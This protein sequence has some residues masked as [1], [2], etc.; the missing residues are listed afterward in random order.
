[1]FEIGASLQE[2][3]ARRGLSPEDVQKAIRIR[4][5]Y[6]TALEEE[7]WEL[8]PGDAYTKGFL[9]SYAEF[10]GLDGNLYVDEYNSRISD[11]ENPAFVPEP[12]PSGTARLGLLRPLVAIAAIVG[13]VAAV[14]AWQLGRAP[15][16][17]P[18]TSPAKKTHTTAKGGTTTHASTTKHRTT[19]K[20]HTTK[21]VVTA[22]HAVLAATNGRVW[23]Q[24]RDGDEAGAVIFEGVLEQGKTLPVTLSP[25]VWVRIGAPWNLE[26]RLGGRVLQG[27]PDQ[28]GNVLVTRSGL[29]P[30]A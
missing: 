21:P 7:R 6:L 20:Q 30:A 4:G 14:A 24:V 3:R 8:L 25:R 10:L 16:S 5:R 13:I 23:L 17:G 18:Q 19:T 12:L 1:M 26:I 27:L 2:A 11:H 29:A 9:R 28:P 15:A 22:T